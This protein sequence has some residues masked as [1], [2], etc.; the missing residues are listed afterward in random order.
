MNDPYGGYDDQ[1]EEE[2][3]ASAPQMNMH[4]LMRQFI[5]TDLN[6]GGR[7]KGR[8]AGFGGGSGAEERGVSHA[9]APSWYPGRD[10]T[11]AYSLTSMQ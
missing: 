5:D 4:G 7:A 1:A 11:V 10:P 8:A 3:H 2:V 6:E 9:L